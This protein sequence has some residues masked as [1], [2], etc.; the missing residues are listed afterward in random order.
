MENNYRI[1]LLTGP[2]HSGKTSTG[3]ALARFINMEFFDLDELIEKAEGKS[4]RALYKEGQEVFQKAEAKALS[5]AVTGNQNIIIAAGGGLID[6]TA[7]MDIIAKSLQTVPVY[8]E[9]SAETAWKRILETSAGSELPAFLDKARPRESHAEI[10]NRR[11]IK[12]K[13][14]ARYIINA[15]NKSPDELAGEISGLIKAVC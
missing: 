2:K 3:R 9:I 10:H 12:Y 1:I 5:H 15:E 13:A 7:A 8:L 4:P 11:A 6:N 14:A